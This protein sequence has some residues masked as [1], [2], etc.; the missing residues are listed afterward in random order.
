VRVLWA[1]WRL[2][3]V[4]KPDER[5]GCIFCD[6]PLLVTREAR[7]GEL[8]LRVTEHASVL[9]NLFPYANGHLLVAPR[10]HVSDFGRLDAA[11]SAHLQAELQRVV[12][13]LTRA[14]SPAGFNVGMNLGRQ[15]GAGID[16][17][18]HWHVVPRWAGDTNFMPVLADT[19]VM[20]EHLLV[21]Y[22]RLLPYFA[23]DVEQESAAGVAAAGRQA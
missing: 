16:D 21:T 4:E 18:L 22:E 19:R 13:V 23:E 15:A 10:V 7:R 3:Y 9:M 14:F 8:V 5:G 20:P 2:A 17:H 12:R 1:P 6:K 11:V